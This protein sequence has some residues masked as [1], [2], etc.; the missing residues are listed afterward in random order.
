[1]VRRIVPQTLFSVALWETEVMKTME[2]P[3]ETK[4]EMKEELRLSCRAAAL[5][6]AKRRDVFDF[7]DRWF[8]SLLLAEWAAAIVLA[9]VFSPLAWQGKHSH[10][11]LHVWIALI[12]GGAICATVLYM[13]MKHPGHLLTRHTIAV[14]QM[15]F[16]ALLIHLSGG[17]IETHFH[18]FGSLA[19]LSFYRDYRVLCTAS[20]VVLV[21]HLVRG[22]LIPESVFGVMTA[23]PWRA[24][25]HVAWV[26]FE[27]VFLIRSCLQGT[28]EMKE[29]AIH[30]DL[31][32]SAS[33]DQRE[34]AELRA[35]ELQQT[36]S[37]LSY[38][39]QTSPT[40]IFRLNSE[41]A[42]VFFNEQFKRITDLEWSDD[43][44]SPIN[45]LK[46]AHHSQYES[47]RTRWEEFLA[48]GGRLEQDVKLE[49][50]S[51]NVKW[52]RLSVVATDDW[53]GQI[54]GYTGSLTDVTGSVLNQHISR[55]QSVVSQV[56][57]RV[58]SESD[59]FTQLLNAIGELG[60][61]QL[62]N[63]WQMDEDGEV[64]RLTQSWIGV[65]ARGHGLLSASRDTELKPGQGLLGCVWERVKPVYFS[66]SEELFSS[67][68]LRAA[69]EDGIKSGCAFPVVRNGKLTAIIEFFS[70]DKVQWAEDSLIFALTTIGSF[71]SHCLYKLETEQTIQRNEQKLA[72]ILE[73]SFDAIFTTDEA[74]LITYWNLE[75]EKIFAICKS[76]ATGLH[77]SS[78]LRSA[79]EGDMKLLESLLGNEQGDF[80]CKRLE[81]TG[82]NS[83][84]EQ[85]PVEVTFTPNKT[86][87]GWLI[88]ALLRDISERKKAEMLT[89]RLALMVESSQDAIIGTFMDGTIS[90]W[91]P[92]AEK[93]YG[94]KADEVLG[95]HISLIVP[96]NRI[97][98]IAEK[99]STIKK[100]EALRDFE[101]VR[102]R[103]DGS[104]VDVSMTASPIKR[105]DGTVEGISVIARD[106]TTRKELEK[107]ISEFYSTVS[108][109]L[110]T[111]LTSIRGSLSL[112]DDEIVELNSEE[113]REMIK[114]AKSSSERLVRL[115]NDILDLRKI[116]SGKLE[117]HLSETRAEDLVR[118][119]L[120]SM[121]GMA[122]QAGVTLTSNVEG[123]FDLSVDEDRIVQV[124]T[125]LLSNAIKYSKEGDSVLL[126]VIASDANLLRFS[127]ID[128]GPGIPMRD[129][130][131]LFGKFQQVDSSDTRPKEGTG[132][133][134]A[135]SKAIVR[136][137]CGIIGVHSREGI[138]STFWFELP[139]RHAESRIASDF[140]VRTMLDLAKKT[141]LIVEDDI[142]LSHMLELRLIKEG[143]RTRAAHSVEQARQLLTSVMPDVVLM[144]LILPDGTGLDLIAEMREN[145]GTSAIPVILVTGKQRDDLSCPLPIVFDWFQK[146]FEAERLVGCVNR[147]CAAV[148]GQTILVVEDDADTRAVM[149]AQLQKLAVRCIEA[150]SAEAAISLAR[151][152]KPDVIILDVGLPDRSGFEVV[153]EL[154]ELKTCALVVYTAL[155]LSASEKSQLTLGMTRHLTKGRVSPGEFIST[156]EELIC[157]TVTQAPGEPP[158][159]GSR[160]A[161]TMESL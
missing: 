150:D 88:T 78:F 68:R 72:N 103:K 21:D 101:T 36:E 70:E 1:M 28:R 81:L 146:P 10:I 99:I 112:I 161:A 135:I 2:E 149:I 48:R 23:S 118:L 18:V 124:L 144:D 45:W 76:E 83:S 104:E 34:L 154:R 89:K 25:E 56:L 116:E 123:T 9:L 12:A 129:Q 156:V 157:N 100:Q 67:R 60:D 122:R 8:A 64:M 85:F 141:V 125:N 31:L 142:G 80:E 58:Q 147:A 155:D 73:S 14:G 59:L 66:S 121:Q 96:A 158:H 11:H 20:V 98:E 133:G 16:S 94:Y 75:A 132:L 13:V 46:L 159:D 69:N 120:D 50:S 74:G 30:E 136:E 139:A 130:H 151:L 49:T 44:P 86:D 39:C 33:E 119:S 32:E 61:W 6:A 140:S 15:L 127:V 43:E 160:F 37:Q 71:V 4:R 115:I 24:L 93:I 105:L 114:I 17:R 42:V 152:V 47:I 126:S 27:D 26:V 109:E 111:P 87:D 113:A 40:G 110:R 84:G 7:T 19:F 134:L 131:K 5:F 38:I 137:H 145:S 41:G 95:Q 108:H 52:V 63:V 51:G 82:T 54:T 97:N 65:G 3:G 143:F 91:N 22:I 153:D 117:L 107:R 55:M 92:G 106:I 138:G 79:V 35:I 53:R 29:E 102:L 57:T 90:N 128:E 148:T 62:G 77:V